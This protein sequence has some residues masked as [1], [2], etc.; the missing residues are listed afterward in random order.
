MS[1][2]ASHSTTGGK[3][4]Q[5]QQQQPNRKRP[6]QALST[7]SGSSWKNLPAFCDAVAAVSAPI[8]AARRLP[9]LQHLWYTS[10]IENAAQQQLIQEQQTS[11]TKRFSAMEIPYLSGGGKRSSRHLRRRITSYAS[12]KRHRFPLGKGAELNQ[13]DQQMQTNL[14]KDKNPCRRARRRNRQ[15]LQLLHQ[16]WT[17]ATTPT[18]VEER[19][20]FNNTLAA[21]VT[22]QTKSKGCLPSSSS[23]SVSSSPLPFWMKT[24][25]WHAKRFHMLDLWK[26]KVPVLHT[27]R[28]ARATLR[29]AREGV[30]LLQD[31]TWKY[32]QPIVL[33]FSC[34]IPSMLPPALAQCFPTT[35]I[36]K[37]VLCGMQVAEGMLHYPNQFPAGA[38]GPVIIWICRGSNTQQPKRSER[39]R[40]YV[41]VHPS[42]RPKAVGSLQDWTKHFTT[43][44]VEIQEPTS[45]ALTSPKACLQLRGKSATSIL[46]HLQLSRGHPT[47]WDWSSLSSCSNLHEL[48]PHGSVLFVKHDGRDMDIQDAHQIGDLIQDSHDLKKS[49]VANNQID[50]SSQIEQMKTKWESNHEIIFATDIDSLQRDDMMLVSHCPRNPRLVH[51]AGCCG[52]DVWMDPQKIHNVFMMLVL[53]GKA[54]PVGMLDE[55]HLRLECEPPLLVFPRDFPDTDEGRNYWQNSDCE[56]CLVRK[57]LEGGWGRLNVSRWKRREEDGSDQQKAIMHRLRPI[58][59]FDLVGDSAAEN[60]EAIAEPIIDAAVATPSASTS[61]GVVV[62]RGAQF[63]QP[64]L[65]AIQ[66][67][68]LLP[69]LTTVTAAKR[70]KRR[71]VKP[72]NEPTRTIP[73]GPEQVELL[74]EMI[75]GLLQALSLPAVVSCRVLIIGRGTLNPGSEIWMGVESQDDDELIGFVTAG[76]FSPTR[77][78]CHGIGIIGTARFLQSLLRI[79]RLGQGTGAGRVVVQPDGS[80]QVEAVVRVTSGK[81]SDSVVISHQAT[82]ALLLE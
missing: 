10:I 71:R 57:C 67:C 1:Q 6:F 26:W 82:M 51:N 36:S 47:L 15:G 34:S 73:N 39:F 63:G 4:Q 25:L 58:N 24:H 20:T 38:I 18:S 72:P 48:L 23:S 9:E 46:A 11:Q 2:S 81:S 54:C 14:K 5:Q 79:S 53:Q 55:A 74:Q 21:N 75:S 30:T 59:W 65:S 16:T 33:D 62:V 69:R 44:H 64:L 31:V 35:E 70:R 12:T 8:Y 22:D 56:W 61:S 40:V 29:M 78:Q 41:W 77:G 3:Q 80:R 76:T 19:H 50:Y 45:V 32:S 66:C 68:G 60:S 43:L 27:N 52:W 42:V 49:P 13:T 7:S 37:S 28:G 17:K